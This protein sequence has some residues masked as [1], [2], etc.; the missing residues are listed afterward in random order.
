MLYSGM[1][2]VNQAMLDD[3]EMR[4]K[5]LNEEQLLEKSDHWQ[6]HMKKIHGEK[7]DELNEYFTDLIMQAEE[8]YGSESLVEKEDLFQKYPDLKDIIKRSN[9]YPDA[10]KAIKRER[11][12]AVANLGMRLPERERKRRKVSLDN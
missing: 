12:E 7:V 9:S 3:A 1:S 11:E 5:A 6:E 2:G 8:Y 4:I 10:A